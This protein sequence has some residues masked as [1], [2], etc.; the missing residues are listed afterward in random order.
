MS[1]IVLGV[2]TSHSPLLAIPPALWSDRAKDDLRKTEL[3][4]GDGRVVTY[5]ELNTEVDA[6]YRD[7]ATPE[8]FEQQYAQ[9]QSELDVL[10]KAVADARVDAMI[11]IG[12]D[13]DELFVRAHLPLMAIYT[14]EEI[15]THPKNEVNP[16]LPD[17]YREANK[18]YKMD[19]VHRYPTNPKLAEALVEGMV[20]EGADVAIAGQ[21]DDPVAAGFG[22]AF[23][24]VMD[25]LGGGAQIP[26]VPIMLNTY[27][28]PNV[29]RPARAWQ[30]GQALA[31]ALANDGMD[32]RVAVV[33]SGGLSHFAVDEDLD[34][35]V[36][37]A[38]AAHDADTLGALDHLG[39]RSGNSEILNWIMTGGAMS[40]LSVVHQTYLPVQRTE[41]GTG[42]GLAFLL[43]TPND[44]SEHA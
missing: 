24:F 44:E 9:A 21:V 14:G 32:L 7:R 29:P 11:V 17:W 6:R 27:F 13:Q 31:A 10:A 33:A 4:L 1:R 18:G 41:A 20:A 36:L 16:N 42:V 37:S 22:H 38:L 2:G 5:D 15:I 39:L 19:T 30:L 25:R 12:D 34:R 43:W 23:G 40:G 26:I 3:V 28:P 35:R 8:H